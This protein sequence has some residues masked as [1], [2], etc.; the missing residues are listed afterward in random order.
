ML[1]DE[2]INEKQIN[3]QENRKKNIKEIAKG[4]CVE[5]YIRDW[6][7][8]YQRWKIKGQFEVIDGNSHVNYRHHLE[9]MESRNSQYIMVLQHF[10]ANKF[11]TIHKLDIVH[12]DFHHGN[13]ITLEHWECWNTG[14]Q[15]NI[16]NTRQLEYWTALAGTY[17][18]GTLNNTGMLEFGQHWITLE[19]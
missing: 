1:N 14:Q 13:I 6:I 7:I 4:G 18:T 9:F 16:E 17:N 8:E 3:Q 12:L 15:R 19:Y 2:N 10:K 11:S 5:G